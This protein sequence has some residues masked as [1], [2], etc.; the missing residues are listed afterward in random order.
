M[1]IP[2]TLSSVPDVLPY[3]QYIAT[4]NQTVFPYPFPI[5]QDADLVVVVNGVTQVT[6]STYS[7][8]GVGN[9]TGGNV[10]FSAGR[11]VNDII[12][13]FR[14]IDIKRITQIGQNSGFSSTAFNAE[15][16]NIYLI[17]QQLEDAIA[18]CLQIPNTNSPNGTTL[19]TPAAY[20]NKYLSFDAN[21]NPTPAVLT[22]VGTLT[23]AILAAL[24]NPQTTFEASV[25]V[26]PTNLVYVEGNGLRYNAIGDGVTDST[27]ALNN[28]AKVA[29]PGL[30]LTLQ[31]NGV[32]MYN[33]SAGTNGIKFSAATGF[34]VDGQMA[35]IRA[36][37]NSTVGANCNIL[38]FDTVTYA[39]IKDLI[40]DGNRA[41]RTIGGDV[42]AANI[43]VYTGCASIHFKNV[44]AIN[45][46][47][48]GIYIAMATPAVQNSYPTDITFED[49]YADNCY[50]NGASV[51][52]S[53]RVKFI[54]GRYTGSVGTAPQAGIDIEPNVGTTFGNTDLELH[55]VDTS[56]NTGYGL[57]I[58]PAGGT[59]QRIRVSGH[60]GQ[61]NG[62]G[63]ITVTG[64]QDLTLEGT[65]IGPHST[66][67]RGL[68]DI[69]SS[70]FTSGV[71]ITNTSAQG[72]TVA[73]SGSKCVIY[74][75]GTVTDVTVIDGISVK[76]SSIPATNT[77]AQVVLSN[78]TCVD[79][80]AASPAFANAGARS[81]FNN[82]TAIRCA[83][84]AFYSNAAADVSVDGIYA[85]DCASST[86][87]IDFDTGSVDPILLNAT[88]RQTVSVPGPAFRFITAPKLV[89]N[90]SAK[91]AGTDYTPATAWSFVGGTLG[92]T[93]EMTTIPPIPVRAVASAAALTIPAGNVISVTGTTN[94]TSMTATNNDQRIVMLVFTGSLT[95]TSG[96][97]LKLTGAA[98][99]STSAGSAITLACD[100]TNWYEI[101][102]KA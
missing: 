101:G 52:G 34:V 4:L 59:N 55:D 28:W 89:G 91:S 96:G 30:L 5:T 82:L 65:K 33:P 49:V 16:N 67:I 76:T 22:S 92:S 15:F 46:V 6:D 102:R 70:T 63:L 56:S 8:S 69:G 97:N 99:F 64:V 75:H 13:L 20:A 35:T 40:T 45:A 36:T 80:T 23:Q 24:L 61:A 38:D 44:Y 42:Q 19:L 26:V 71:K 74:V 57:S 25:G 27:V 31:P 32:Y 9:P 43:Q 17:M 95:F 2:A 7:V 72:I 50:R 68:I 47:E 84:R 48:D 51:I 60:T 94:I 73:F 29:H 81:R 62:S 10:T 90:A 39:L 88:V 98:S 77:Q 14:D 78:A 100:G 1:T 83:D 66:C 21:G 79:M 41:N 54:R 3:Q 11:A 12:T 85:E 18:F 37:A 53:R 86:A 87:T 58:A 93:I